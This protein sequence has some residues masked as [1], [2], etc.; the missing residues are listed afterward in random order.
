MK[1]SSISLVAAALA[2]LVVSAI[3]APRSL[4]R[5]NLFERGVDG[6]RVDDLYTR[7]SK[8]AARRRAYNNHRALAT[9]H[10]AAWK[11]HKKAYNNH[12]IAS[13]TVECPMTSLWHKGQAATHAELSTIHK[14]RYRKNSDA[15]PN[16]LRGT[17]TDEQKTLL[18]GGHR[19]QV[20]VAERSGNEAQR[21]SDYAV[22]V[23]NHES[24]KDTRDAHLHPDPGRYELQ[25]SLGNPTV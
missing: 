12:I 19:P 22:K 5:V 2:T 25:N 6:E 13:D 3:A 20:Q 17:R 4:E 9:A 1:L 23:I 8:Q 11:S 10:R 18:I 15:A 14:G 7:E 21:S 24:F 16:A